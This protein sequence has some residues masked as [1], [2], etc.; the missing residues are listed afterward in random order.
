MVIKAGKQRATQLNNKLK[1]LIDNSWIEIVFRWI[2]GITFI[3]ASYYK[4]MSPTDFAKIIYGYN[5]FPEV[6]INLIAIVLPFVELISGFCLLLG[7]YPRSAALIIN[8]LLAAFIVILTINLIRGYEFD[9]GCFSA[10]TTMSPKM[11]VA[12]D[13]IYI[14]MGLQVFFFNGIRKGC[15]IHPYLPGHGF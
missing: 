13:V 6:L 4:I 5:L 12:R 8:G 2:L 15:F 1:N 10:E 9:C 14:I 7:I 3:Y 11:M